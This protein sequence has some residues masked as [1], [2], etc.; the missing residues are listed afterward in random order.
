MDAAIY[1]PQSCDHF[2]GFGLGRYVA[3][4]VGFG[5]DWMIASSRLGDLGDL[6]DLGAWLVCSRTAPPGRPDA[7]TPVLGGHDDPHKQRE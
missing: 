4:G 2:L 3:F 1:A 7:R 6:G 5:D